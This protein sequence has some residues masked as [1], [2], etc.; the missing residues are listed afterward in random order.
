MDQSPRPNRRRAPPPTSWR[1]PPQR[2]VHPTYDGRPMA[3]PPR[4]QAA[5]GP[6]TFCANSPPPSANSS[7]PSA[8]APP[9][10]T[11]RPPA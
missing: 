6:V 9:A 10:E 3:P 11:A 8:N 1:P 2:S 5:A 7:P 4:A